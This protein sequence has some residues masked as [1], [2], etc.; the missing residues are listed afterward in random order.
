M[1][2]LSSVFY[3]EF[4]DGIQKL[5][6]LSGNSALFP[7]EIVSLL[8]SSGVLVCFT[9]EANLSQSTQLFN[10]FSLKDSCFRLP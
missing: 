3:D 9:D 7:D 8:E 6:I 1:P 5:V 4:P 10:K 2:F